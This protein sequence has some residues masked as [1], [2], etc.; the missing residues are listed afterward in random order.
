MQYIHHQV[1]GGSISPLNEYKCQ[2]CGRITEVI[3]KFSDPPLTECK[4]WIELN[5]EFKTKC[6]GKLEKL[7]SKSSFHL[8]GT[9]WG[10]DAN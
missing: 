10:K 9:G 1:I 8:K 7:I 2:K 6:K 3:Q 4:E 5:C